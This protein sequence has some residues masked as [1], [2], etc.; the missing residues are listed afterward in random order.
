[1]RVGTYRILYEIIDEALVVRVVKVDHR[2]D[3]YR[4]L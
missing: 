4:R 2:R 1:M 3:I